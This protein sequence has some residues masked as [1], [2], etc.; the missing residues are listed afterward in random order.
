MIAFSKDM[1]KLLHLDLNGSIRRNGVV[2]GFE[3]KVSGMQCQMI[4]ADQACCVLVCHHCN[5]FVNGL[6]K[7]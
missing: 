7:W 5:G 4:G 2:M 6:L 3:S 1:L